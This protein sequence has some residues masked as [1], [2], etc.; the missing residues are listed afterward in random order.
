MGENSVGN[1]N[2]V[3][4]GFHFATLNRLGEIL[5]DNSHSATI[6]S[7]LLPP[8]FEKS[9]K[10]REMQSSIA[11]SKIVCERTTPAT[12]QCFG[13]VQTGKAKFASQNRWQ[14]AA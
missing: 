7:I 11:T 5:R 3:I 1:R 6:Q 4:W 14:P 10:N 12:A 9:P 13:P 2:C 8:C